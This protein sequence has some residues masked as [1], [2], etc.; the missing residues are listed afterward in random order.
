MGPPLIRVNN[1]ILE[2]FIFYLKGKTTWI[3]Y[4]IILTS[5]SV[6]T[7]G[8]VW[9]QHFEGRLPAEQGATIRCDILLRQFI[10]D[11]K[12]TSLPAPRSAHSQSHQPETQM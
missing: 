10:F 9:V 12:L 3:E 4:V 2:H 8:Q 5:T 11:S 1:N 7:L 6:S